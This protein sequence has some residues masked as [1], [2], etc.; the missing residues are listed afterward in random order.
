MNIDRRQLIKAGILGGADAIVTGEPHQPVAAED[1]VRA[2]IA[3]YALRRDLV[4]RP[5]PQAEQ[6]QHLSDLI[7]DGRRRANLTP[8]AV[9]APAFDPEILTGCSADE[10]LAAANSPSA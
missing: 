6:G 8:V 2:M 3:E 7:A 1:A 10:V 4:V 9:F 5:I